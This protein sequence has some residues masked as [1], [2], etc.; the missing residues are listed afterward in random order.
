MT[1]SQECRG[2]VV[3]L[4]YHKVLA[5]VMHQKTVVRVELLR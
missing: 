4:L 3:E 5:A 1:L 2:A